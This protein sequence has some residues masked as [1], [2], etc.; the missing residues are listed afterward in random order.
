MGT[1]VRHRTV[2]T[3]VQK[4]PTCQT[5]R[6]KW[7]E[8]WHLIFPVTSMRCWEV[9]AHR[10]LVQ[11]VQ[12]PGLGTE[13]R[14]VLEAAEGFCAPWGRLEP[15]LVTHMAWV[16]LAKQVQGA[17]PLSQNFNGLKSIIDLDLP[18]LAPVTKFPWILTEL[19]FIHTL[20]VPFPPVLELSFSK[21]INISFFP[22][23]LS[24]PSLTQHQDEEK[25][26]PAGLTPHLTKLKIFNFVISC[27]FQSTPGCHLVCVQTK[28]FVHLSQRLP[29]GWRRPLGPTRAPINPALQVH[30]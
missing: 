26:A 3:N 2:E 19:H 9:P 13:L 11:P 7:W 6:N 8:C 24:F 23:K 1:N 10:G 4:A 20:L 18:L 22:L 17:E 15:W 27:I 29:E 25:L 30:H 16:P 14:C 21:L 5:G 28:R 12:S